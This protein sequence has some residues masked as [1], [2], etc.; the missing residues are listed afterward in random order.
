MALFVLFTEEL[1]KLDSRA[2]NVLEDWRICRNF[3][4]ACYRK[5]L[6]VRI[7]PLGWR[8]LPWREKKNRRNEAHHCLAIHEW[9]SEWPETPEIA[10]AICSSLALRCELRSQP[11]RRSPTDGVR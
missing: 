3:R 11:L 10:N 4:R 1:L 5:E 9:T 8:Q 2:R 6:W 7:A